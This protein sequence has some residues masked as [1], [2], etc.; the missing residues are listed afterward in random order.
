[1]A[2]YTM[3]LQTYIE[4]WSQYE[5]GLSTAERIERGRQKLFDFSYPIFDENYRKVFETHFIRNFYMREIGFETEG[6]FKFH[7]ET[8][9]LINMPYWNKMFESELIEFDPLKN[10][11]VTKDYNRKKDRNQN[12]NRDIVENVTSDGQAH[13]TDKQ[14][15]A[16]NSVTDQTHGETSS[17]QKDSTGSVTDN[18]FSREVSAKQPDSRLALTTN[19]GEG[20][21]EYADNIE[22]DSTNNKRNTTDKQTTSGKMDSTDHITSDTKANSNA[23]GDATTHNESDTTRN[24]KLASKINDLEDYISHEV[25]K[26]GTE[27]YQEMIQKYRDILLRIEVKIFR[28][29]EQL[30]MLVY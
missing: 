12:D 4:K 23:V 13:T 19:D 8:W 7:L 27:T 16:S 15:M 6:L 25:G 5:E 22:E 14:D 17:G 3:K 2:S 1:M 11:D 18:N 9:L 24:D 20:V 29:M 30:F 10:V 28:E 21:I 26:I